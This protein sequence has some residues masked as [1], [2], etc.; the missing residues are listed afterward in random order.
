[1]HHGDVL[2][3]TVL[4]DALKTAMPDCSVDMLV[5]KGMEDV[6]WDNPLISQVHVVD[7]NW[8]KEG[9]VF[10]L[11]QEIA[12]V[13]WIQV[14]EYD[15]VFNCSDRWRTALITHYSGAA[16]KIGFSWH[17]RRNF[18][19]R[20]MFTDLV[21]P[22]GPAVHMVDHYLK[23]LS[24]L[25]M[26]LKGYQPKVSM[27]IAHASRKSLAQKLIDRGWRGEEYVLMHPGSRWFFKCWD[28]DKTAVL[29]KKLL[30]SGHNVVLTAAPD[31]REHAMLEKLQEQIHIA[32]PQK[33]WVLDGVLT[34]RELAAAIERAKLFI[35]VD[36]VPMHMA[37]ALYKPQVALFGPSWVSRWRPHSDL[38]EV[39]WAGD[40]GE[41]PHPDSIDVNT[42]ERYL[43]AIPVEAV[44]DAVQKRLA[45]SHYDK[46][47][48]RSGF[49]YY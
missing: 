39:V 2:L 9:K 33:L 15:A 10:Q 28:D 7:R 36:S 5:Y 16:K 41:L 32:L 19:W 46:S 4:A 13:R 29:L 31:P 37:A 30:E 18:V 22:Q 14:Q 42:R 48:E 8:K 27:G 38:A 1:M 45:G 44:W 21:E 34:L 35:G 20:N 12:L 25:D 24:P 43:G 49:L 6:V 47:R 40:Y 17:S 23:L 26:D 11:Q 3:T